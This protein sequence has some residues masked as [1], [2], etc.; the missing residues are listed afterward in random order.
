MLSNHYLEP[1]SE[2]PTILEL[3]DFVLH[4]GVSR[5][6]PRYPNATPVERNAVDALALAEMGA[7]APVAEAVLAP[8]R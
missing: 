4:Y 7:R 1:V 5:D 3:G 8:L 6:P 2:W